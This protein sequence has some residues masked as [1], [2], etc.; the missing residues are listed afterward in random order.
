[1]MQMFVREGPPKEG[2]VTVA[3]DL[4]DVVEMQ[5]AVL[6]RNFELL[7]RRGKV[8][9]ELD[10]AE[11]LLLRT[12]E[13]RGPLDIGTLAAAL[14]LDPSTAGRQ[15]GQMHTAGLLSREPAPDDRRRNIVAATAAG[16]EAADAVRR[17]RRASIADLLAD[18]DPQDVDTLG[19][20]FTRYNGAVAEKYLTTGT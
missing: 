6:V 10:G 8:Y 18:W 16:R 7:R 15:V 4:L 19:E 14:G 20:M 11:Y 2:A 3:A 5:S 1:M 9:T 12:L 13:E 17:R